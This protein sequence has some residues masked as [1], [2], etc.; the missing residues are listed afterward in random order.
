M[1]GKLIPNPTKNYEY[2]SKFPRA[3]NTMQFQAYYGG[4]N[5]GVYIGLEDPNG[6]YRHTSVFGKYNNL[7]IYW[8]TEIPVPE[9]G[10]LSKF[11]LGGNSK[12]A[13]YQ[14]QWY[15]AGQMYKN[16]LKYIYKY[17]IINVYKWALCNID[18][19]HAVYLCKCSNEEEM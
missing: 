13:L 2:S 18:K 3:D 10:K 12:I 8:Q 6:T 9:K 11:V 1:S 4:K 16:F 5:D 7:H 17:V 19:K 15:E 14:G